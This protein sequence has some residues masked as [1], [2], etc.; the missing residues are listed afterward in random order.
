MIYV[1]DRRADSTCPTAEE[2]FATKSSYCGSHLDGCKNTE[3]SE[4]CEAD[5]DLI[6]HKGEASQRH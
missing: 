3:D 6:L 2:F 5:V 1:R 4:S